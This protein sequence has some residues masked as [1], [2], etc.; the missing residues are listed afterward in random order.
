MKITERERL[1][2]RVLIEYA[3]RHYLGYVYGDGD[4]R[5]IQASHKWYNLY[6]EY[7]RRY[8][9]TPLNKDY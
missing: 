4:E 1:R 6:R 2:R 3:K 5:T 7:K 9:D 8:N